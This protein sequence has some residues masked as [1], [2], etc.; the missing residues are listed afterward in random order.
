MKFIK[1]DI[2]ITT[3]EQAFKLL[4]EGFA[5]KAK[6]TDFVY[7]SNGRLV[8]YYYIA[9]PEDW[10]CYE[11]KEPE[12]WETYDWKEPVFCFVS[13]S[14][15]FPE[16]DYI[17]KINSVNILADGSPSFNAEFSSDWGWAIPVTPEDIKELNGHY[18]DSIK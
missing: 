15:R 11:I 3:Q 1:T 17:V 4:V 6:G 2:V 14:S 18:F 13:S 10:E 9:S 8:S 16:K 12:W 5:L 7:F